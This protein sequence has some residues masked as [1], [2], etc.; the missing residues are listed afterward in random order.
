MIDQ[1]ASKPYGIHG[2][3]TNLSTRFS[4]GYIRLRCEQFIDVCLTNR[5]WIEDV[6]CCISIGISSFNCI[7]NPGFLVDIVK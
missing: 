2:N 4:C 3:C 7:C 1:C 5:C 6:E